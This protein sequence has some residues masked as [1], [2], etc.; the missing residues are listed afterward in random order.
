LLTQR[1]LD[2][3]GQGFKRLWPIEETPCFSTL[4]RA[5]EEA[6]LKLQRERA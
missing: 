5:I 1:D 4:L 3:L 6:D 2:V